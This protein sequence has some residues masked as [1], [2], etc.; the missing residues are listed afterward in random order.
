MEYKILLT[1]S[2]GTHELPALEVPLTRE[3]YEKMTTVEALSG[4]VYD[5]YI[6]TKRIWTHTWAY[7]SKEEY[8]LLDE[9]YERA[10]SEF[11]YPLLT[12][13]GEAV[14]DVVVR[15][16]LSPKNIVDNCGNVQGVSVTF[17]E[18][19]QLGS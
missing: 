11:T 8:D 7:L 14:A 13:N 15:Y 9:I 2:D 12:I 3:N 4:N 19:R 18:T 10:K 17:R 1:D 6:S 5:D 16:E